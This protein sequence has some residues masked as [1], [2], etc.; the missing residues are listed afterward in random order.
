MK[1][2]RRIVAPVPKT[3]HRSGS[4]LHRERPRPSPLWVK[5]R[6]VQ[7]TRRCLLSAKSG[8]V[9]RSK[10]GRLFHHLVGATLHRLWHGNAERLGGL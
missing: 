4:N 1:S 10:E 3:W 8:L 2:R 9:R 6:H 5:S 7:C